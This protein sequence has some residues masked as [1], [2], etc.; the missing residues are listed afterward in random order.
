MTT[1][2]G[3]YAFGTFSEN[4]AELERLQRQASIAWPI[5]RAALRAA[6]LKPG[7]AVADLACG[8]G[9]LSRLMA[10]EVGAEGR[11]TGVELNTGLLSV[12]RALPLTPGGSVTF[13]EGNVYDLSNLPAGCFD[14]A[15]ARFLFQHLE[16]PLDAL[17]AIRRILKPGGRLL[18]ADSD[19]AL[20]DV[21]P[22]PAALDVLLQ[23]A[24]AGQQAR[25]GDRLI[26]RQLAGLMHRA[27]FVGVRPSVVSVTTD[28]ID[29]VSF[30]E[31]TT[32][33]KVELLPEDRRAWA[34]DL[35]AETYAAARDGALY[36]S[37]GVYFTSGVVPE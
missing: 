17:A 3:S 10:E 9:I 33:F 14:I 6:G 21:V 30:L 4:E 1:D 15:Y 34:R 24:L 7:M 11:V 22:R 28:D 8:P 13:E 32:S 31:I 19:D 23:E 20:F 12:A 2:L 36:G 5:E 16:R 37:V 18:I 25:G 29:P 26:G 35:L 27:G